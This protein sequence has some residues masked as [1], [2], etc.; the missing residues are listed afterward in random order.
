MKKILLSLL[1]C[2]WGSGAF[3]APALQEGDLVFQSQG[4]NFSKA[5]QLA[6]HSPYNHMGMV[7]I[8]KEKPYVLEAVGPVKFTSLDRWIKNG[9]QD[10]FVAKRLK[11]AKAVL[12]PEVLQKMEAL[13][14]KYQGKGYTFT[15]DWSDQKFYCSGLVWRIY[16]ETTG[17]EVGKFQKLGDLDLTNSL[18]KKELKKHFGPFVPL[19]HEIISPEQMFES[20]LLS[21]VI[22]Q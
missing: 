20:D 9:K 14:R 22:E 6:T 11:N 3:A 7:F 2:I 13:A 1:I 8:R 5:I 10:H 21:T 19:D 18:V 12:T 4:G 16:H 17:L 15:F